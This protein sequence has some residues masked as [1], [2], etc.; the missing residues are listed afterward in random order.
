[1]SAEGERRLLPLTR[2]GEQRHRRYP[3]LVL[4]LGTGKLPNWAACLRRL[5]ISCSEGAT[6]PCC[7]RR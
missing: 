7:C 6:W 4:A 5:R 1:V 3:G 2:V